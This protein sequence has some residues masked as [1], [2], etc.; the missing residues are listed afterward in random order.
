MSEPSGLLLVSNFLVP[1]DWF[2]PAPLFGILWHNLES[3]LTGFTTVSHIFW[4]L[5]AGLLLLRK[6]SVVSIV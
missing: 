1:F 6:V 5:E 3:L 2:A 4:S